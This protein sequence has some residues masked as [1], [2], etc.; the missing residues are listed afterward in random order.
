MIKR[1]KKFILE[2]LLLKNFIG[3]DSFIMKDIEIVLENLA[4]QEIMP[5]KQQ[6]LFLE[7]FIEFD[8]KYKHPSFFR[9]NSNP[10]SLYLWGPVG[11]GKTLL[12]QA[13]D[14]SYFKNSGQFH[15][16]EFM[17]LIHKSL[18]EVSSNKEPLTLVAQKIAKNYDMLVI[19][20]FQIEDIADAMIIGS[21][22]ESLV[23]K[24]IRIMLSSNAHPSTLY[25]DGL[26]RNKF[27]PAIEFIQSNF[28]IF[29]LDGLEDYRLRDIVSVSSDEPDV[30]DF[31]CKTFSEEW[32]ERNEFTVNERSFPCEGRSS[33]FL[34]LSFQDFFSEPCGSK[35]FIEIAKHY[36][37]VFISN[38]HACDDEH[39]D[40]IRRFIS[41]IDITYQE[42]QKMKLFY[43]DGFLKNF[44]QGAQLK[45]LWERSE[46]R[47]HEISSSS[48]LSNLEKN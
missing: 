12:M 29:N 48:Y 22:I 28:M 1:I 25:R 39:L 27:L 18:F 36:E 38:F 4:S 19:D 8:S 34:W 47:L 26:Q 23:N 5:D 44:Y 37:W 10:G 3:T 7:A 40:K 2:S 9:Q 32:V 15:F 35:D 42:R 16:L 30:K 13:I 46:S 6:R 20:E 43:K 41:F 14:A 24:G 33:K 17:Q 11:R 21:V 31:L 45:F